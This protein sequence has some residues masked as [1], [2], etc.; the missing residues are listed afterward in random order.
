MIITLAEV[1]ATVSRMNEEGQA[2]LLADSRKR[3]EEN[4]VACFSM[5]GIGT[6]IES[7]KFAIYEWDQ[8]P[9]FEKEIKEKFKA[10]TRC[11]PFDGQ[12]TDELLPLRGKNTV[13]VIIARSF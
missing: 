4:T 7:G 2:K 1:M 13:R 6:A 10:T 3:V 11:I 5:E 8:N 9:E 12:F